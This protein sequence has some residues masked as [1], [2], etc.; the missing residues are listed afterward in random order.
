MG[1]VLRVVG[2]RFVPPK[3]LWRWHLATRSKDVLILV[4]LRLSEKR[5]RR[6]LGV[7]EGAIEVRFKRCG[8]S[9][10]IRAVPGAQAMANDGYVR[11]L[12]GYGAVDESHLHR[13]QDES[14]HLLLAG[15]HRRVVGGGL[16]LAH[17]HQHVSLG[18]GFFCDA[19]VA[20]S[21]KALDFLHKRR[22]LRRVKAGS[23][24]ERIHAGYLVVL[25]RR[26]A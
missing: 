24:V 20:H 18:L 23:R 1:R 6:V 7:F 15:A 25:F 11:L 17:P 16:F 26:G 3:R 5:F 12:G 9:H 14:Q 4:E 22:R 10:G 21:A 19:M 8:W 2:L 13:R